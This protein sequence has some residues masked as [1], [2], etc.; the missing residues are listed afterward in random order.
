MDEEVLSDAVK[1]DLPSPKTN[2]RRAKAVSRPRSERGNHAR[3]ERGAE[4]GGT[5][6]HGE[7]LNE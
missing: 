4:A 6:I 7:E 5:K 1:T 3:A 2:R